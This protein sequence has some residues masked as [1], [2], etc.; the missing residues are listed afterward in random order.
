MMGELR[1]ARP[2]GSASSASGAPGSS[3]AGS[4]EAGS[5]ESEHGARARERGEE[6][7]RLRA[8]EAEVEQLRDELAH[9]A[10]GEMAR[11]GPR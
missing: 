1:H 8:A 10:E 2:G 9:A 4:S 6:V 11:D 5:S 3:E 7:A